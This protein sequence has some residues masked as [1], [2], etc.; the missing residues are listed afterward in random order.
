[1]SQQ[2]EVNRGGETAQ[3]FEIVQEIRRQYRRVNTMGTQLTV[4]LN[5]PSSPDTSPIDH[6]LASVND[7]FEHAL[8]GAADGDMVGIAI[9]NE[10]N[11]NDK[12]ISISFRRRDQLPVD[13]IWSV[14]ERVTQSNARFNALDTLTVVVHSV[15][16]PVGFGRQGH[17]IKTMGRTISVIAHLRSSIVQVKSETNRLA[18]ALI[19]AI[20]R[21]TN[22]PNYKT[23]SKGLKIY[24]R[25]AQLLAATYIS[26]DNGGGIPELERFHDHFRHYKIVVY[27]G[28]NCDDIMFEGRVD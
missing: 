18:H 12:P 8:R 19:N 2:S 10:S 22:G 5:A 3:R 23:Y 17:G 7:L 1:M 11:Q 9:H 26:L 20:A 6:F 27:T 14:L 21:A 25:V 4:R 24:P 16:M 15:T 13:A 28:L